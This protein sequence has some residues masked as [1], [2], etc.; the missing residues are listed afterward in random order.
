MSIAE[1]Q[2][3]TIFLANHV[4]CY[5]GSVG[6]Q[7]LLAVLD[8]GSLWWCG[9]H[10][11]PVIGWPIPQAPSHHCPSTSC[12]QDRLCSRFCGW[13]A[14]PVLLL[15]VFPGTDDPSHSDRSKMETQSRFGLHFPDT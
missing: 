5:T 10:V 11:S 1:C 3:T 15:N 9:P 4:L 6:P 13:V 12:R 2:K 8:V 14:V 7:L